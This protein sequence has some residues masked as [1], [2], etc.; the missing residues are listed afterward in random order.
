[1]VPSAA[2]RPKHLLESCDILKAHGPSALTARAPLTRFS[3][4]ALSRH[5]LGLEEVND[6]FG[7]TQNEQKRDYDPRGLVAFCLFLLPAADMKTAQERH[8]SRTGFPRVGMGRWLWNS[9]CHWPNQGRR[10]SFECVSMYQLY[11]VFPA[12]SWLG[13]VVF[14]QLQPPST[15]IPQVRQGFPTGLYSTTWNLS[16]SISLV[17][18]SSVRV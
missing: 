2:R 10:P 5:A 11:I 17:K 6:R 13:S 18:S 14:V 4:Q 9:C 16:E 7:A 3:S 15:W 8:A 12:A 1:M